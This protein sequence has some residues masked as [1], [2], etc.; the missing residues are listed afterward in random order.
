MKSQG[1]R[2]LEYS[3][4]DI[5]QP[6]LLRENSQQTPPRTGSRPNTPPPSPRA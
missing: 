6:T 5:N 4:I 2:E 3:S 1:K